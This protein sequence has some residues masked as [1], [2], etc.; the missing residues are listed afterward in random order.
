MAKIEEWSNKEIA[1]ACSFTLLIDRIY[2]QIQCGAGGQFSFRNCVSSKTDF[3]EWQ[4]SFREALINHLQIGD[5][6]NGRKELRLVRK[7]SKSYWS[8]KNYT[9]E[10]LYLKSW[11]DTLIPI[12][13]S[14]PKE[15]P[16]GEKQA[17]M[18]CAHGHLMQ[19]ENLVG[20]KRNF[21]Y[22]GHWAKNFA[23]MGCITV[24]LDQWGF[25]E[26][27]KSIWHKLKSGHNFDVYERKYAQNLLEFGRTIAGLRTFDVI[28]LID[29]LHTRSD[30]DLK[31]IG[32]SGL[33]MGGLI[34]SLAAAIDERI[35]LTVI[36]GYLNTF[37][38]SIINLPQKHCADMYIPGMLTLG[39]ESD[40]LSLIAPRPLCFIVGIKDGLFP[41][42]GATKAFTAIEKAYQL[43][44]AM[45]NCV[46]D[47]APMGHGWRGNIAYLFVKKKWN[48]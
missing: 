37:K 11:M 5:L 38:D 21:I 6:L 24:S 25:G 10:Q 22:R 34:A 14:T 7:S 12:L 48:L 39:E 2:D 40:L 15:I 20:K 29:Y 8:E 16:E 1:E 19:K 3:E 28:R 32:I 36:A 4:K 33:S 35:N 13:I 26:R 27:G 44:D 46:L 30:V 45:D 47:K 31:R 41:I 9:L 18:I 42:A 23:E 43:L 17:T